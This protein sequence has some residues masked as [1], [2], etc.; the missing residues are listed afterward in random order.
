VYVRSA[1]SRV[2]RSAPR[3]TVAPLGT[4]DLKGKMRE[5]GVEDNEAHL[6]PRRSGRHP[7]CSSTPEFLIYDELA[8]YGRSA[9]SASLRLVLMVSIGL[10]VSGTAV[11]QIL[12]EG[13]ATSPDA[14]WLIGA[15][16]WT[17]R[18]I[19]AVGIAIIVLG[20]IV[21]SLY[22]LWQLLN[23]GV[24]ADSYQA[25]RANLGRGILLG[26][27][28]LIAADII[29]TVA[30]EPTLENLGVLAIIVLIRT[31]LSFTLEV[32]IQGRWPW[33]QARI[34]GE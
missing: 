30:F 18:G 24:L 13:A 5:S 6:W 19:E 16:H 22:F 20:A 17:A 26:L 15:L 12:D 9:M 10:I 31:F 3:V 21:S 25:Y 11:A 33:Q 7:A 2:R 28:F 29:G 23:G 14:D 34:R 32:E 27:E 4:G 1:A 8:S